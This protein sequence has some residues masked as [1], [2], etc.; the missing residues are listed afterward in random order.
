[1][2]L[3]TWLYPARWVL[4]PF[5]G[6]F[7]FMQ[8]GWTG[9]LTAIVGCFSIVAGIGT[10]IISPDPPVAD[11]PEIQLAH[12][13]GGALSAGGCALGILYG[14]WR[15]GFAWAILGH[16]LGIILPLLVAVELMKRRKRAA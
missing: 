11:A 2:N 8:G 6:V 7:G 5:L 16:F 3:T 13:V 12:R 14:G 9:A 4:A 1:M 10:A 15:T